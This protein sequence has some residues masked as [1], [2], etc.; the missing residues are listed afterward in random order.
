MLDRDGK[1]WARAV[2]DWHS[3]SPHLQQV[4]GGWVIRNWMRFTLLAQIVIRANHALR[5]RLKQTLQQ[6][7]QMPHFVAGPD[8]LLLAAITTGG[9]LLTSVMFDNE[10]LRVSYLDEVVRVLLRGNS[11]VQVSTIMGVRI[12][13]HSREASSAR[14]VIRA[15]QAFLER[16]KKQNKT[17][18]ELAY[19]SVPIYLRIAH[20]TNSMV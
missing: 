14:I 13:D 7:W 5:K 18:R 1:G 6:V 3:G 8:N 4:M 11:W 12:R 2:R 17:F 19:I 15:I 10:S 16:V 9:V 20:V